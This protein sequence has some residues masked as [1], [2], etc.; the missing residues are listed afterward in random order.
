MWSKEYCRS[1]EVSIPRLG[2]KR[3]QGFC[4]GYSHLRSLLEMPAAS[5]ENTHSWRGPCGYLPMKKSKGWNK[6]TRPPDSSHLSE[7]RNRFSSP[8]QVFWCLQPQPTINYNLTRDG[9]RTIQLCHGGIP[10]P[11]K[12][13]HNECLLFQFG[14]ISYIT[15][16][17]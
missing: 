13:C 8:S 10:D 6:S 17:K 14:V 5:C 7:V 1:D 9:V 11:V 15:K 12:L 16:D 4:L 2:Y 3:C